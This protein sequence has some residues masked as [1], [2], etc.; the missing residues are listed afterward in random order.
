LTGEEKQS[1]AAQPTRDLTAYDLYLK[2][3]LLWS[4]RGG[5]NR[6]RAWNGAAG[7][8]TLAAQGRPRAELFNLSV[9]VSVSAMTLPARILF[10]VF[11]ISLAS[12]T[13][14]LPSASVPTVQQKHFCC[15]DMNVNAGQRCPVNPGGTNSKSAPICCAGP[16]ICLSLYVANGNDFAASSQMSGTVCTDD[17]RTTGRAQ[18]PPVPPPRNAVC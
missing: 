6:A 14:V 2:G 12:L 15:A 7:T 16:A 4:K 9:C 3:R 8:D 13:P 5:D 17:D 18:R 11:A 10:S 1:I